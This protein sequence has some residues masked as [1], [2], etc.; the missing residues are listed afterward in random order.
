MQPPKLIRRYVA[1]ASVR[2]IVLCSESAVVLQFTWE[3][4]QESL[5]NRDPN[6]SPF[7]AP[8]P[9]LLATVKSILSVIGSSY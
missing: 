9:N 1:I 3:L 6:P 5:E 4:Q 8:P 7:A 2:I